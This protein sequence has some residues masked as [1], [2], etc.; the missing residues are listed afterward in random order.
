M[1]SKQPTASQTPSAEPVAP[2][3]KRGLLG[4]FFKSALGCTAFAFGVFVVLV[5]LLPTL[6][7]GWATGFAR[8]GFNNTFK[9]SVEIAKIDLAWFSEQRIDGVV[10]RDPDQ[11]EVARAAV[12]MPSLL[13]LARSGQ[14]RIGRVVLDVDADL[15]QDDGGLTNLQ[16]ALEPRHPAD[17]NAPEP[18][19]DAISDFDPIEWL[20][21]LEL[22]LE[23]RSKRLTWSD[24]ETRRIGQPFEVRELLTTVKARPKS[25][26]V[27]HTTGKIVAEKPGA[28][29]IDATIA[30]PITPAKA[31][32]LGKVDAQVR[33]EGFSTAMIDGLAGMQGNLTEVLGQRFT[34]KASVSAAALDAGKLEL[35]LDGERAGIALAAVLEGGVLRTGDK[36]G[37]VASF[38][39]PRGFLKT[40]IDPHLPS[41]SKLVLD[42]GTEPWS[43][44]AA[45]FSVPL[46]PPD[47][48]D[49]KSLRATLEQ[50]A[51]DLQIV[52]PSRFAF[53][54]EMTRAGGVQFALRNIK[55]SVRLAPGT[56]VSAHVE[57]ALESGTPGSFSFDVS[58]R[59]AWEKLAAD[60]LPIVDLELRVKELSTAAIGGLAGES[61][62]LTAA[63][64]RTLNISLDGKKVS[65]DAGTLTANIVGNEG[66]TQRLL[67]DVSARVEGGHMLI[68][69]ADKFSVR[70][71]PSQEWLSREIAAVAPEG[72]E[73]VVEAGANAVTIE[74]S[75]V[76]VPM[77][78]PAGGDYFKSL[79]S[80]AA[81]TLGVRVAGFSYADATLRAANTRVA[82]RSLAID[83]SLQAGGAFTTAVKG[84]FEQGTSRGKLVVDASGSDLFAF[85][86]PNTPDQWPPLDAKVLVSN[87]PAALADAFLQHQNIVERA[88]GKQISLAFDAKGVSTTKGSLRVEVEAPNAKVSFSGKVEGG[89]FKA[90]GDDA[91]HVE[92]RV[93]AQVLTAELADMLPADTQLKF[94][95][96]VAAL[97]LDVRD[98]AVPVPKLGDATPFDLAATLD[99]VSAKVNAT[100]AGVGIEN[101]QTQELK[102]DVVARNI[103]LE[104]VVAPRAPLAVKLKS[105]LAPGRDAKLVLEATLADPFAVLKDKPL[106]PLDAKIEL[107]GLDTSVLDAVAGQ[108]GVLAGLLGPELRVV[109]QANG[110]SATSGAL[111]IDANSP[112]MVFRT[113]ARFD[114]EGL[115]CEGEDGIDV[116][117]TPTAAFVE[118]YTRQVLP[119]GTR[120][121]LANDAGPL[122]VKVRNVL[123][124]LPKPAADPAAGGAPMS[125]DPA[126]AGAPMSSR[127]M[128]D[129]ISKLA[130][131]VEANVP[132][133]IYADAAT[134]AASRPVTLQNLR[135]ASTFKPNDLPFARVFGAIVDEPAGEI[136]AEVRALDPLTKLGEENGLATFRA[137]IDVRA[138]RVPTAILDM[139]AGQGGLLVEALG[140]RLDLTVAAPEISQTS[141]AFTLQMRSDLHGIVGAGHIE[142]G[143]IVVDHV[144]GLV[145]TVGLGPVMS[146][147]VVG[148]LVPTMVAVQKPA[149]ATPAIFAVDALRFP[150][151]G[152]LRKLDGSV[153][154][155]LGEVSYSLF[156]KLASFL[157][158]S[159]SMAPAKIPVITVPI[160]KGV[161]GYS[162]LPVKIGAKEYIFSGTY[163]MVTDAAQ[164]T[165]NVPVSVLGKQVSSELDKLREYIDPALTLPLTIKGSLLNPSIGVDEKGL[166]K[167]IEDAGKKA[168]EKAGSGL[169]DDLF[170][171]KKKD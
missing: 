29:S 129:Q 151:D 50:V 170:K 77:P 165:A 156:P 162:R 120:I 92:A 14:T 58:A 13:A 113:A 127:D 126:A 47:A 167:V 61:E 90:A 41:G 159:S 97:T 114:A 161:A 121:Q 166:R 100:I 102:L 83:A 111:V 86:P 26:I 59:D 84:D 85:A 112:T 154:V 33:V 93:P 118:R 107:S 95:N 17:P 140:S 40:Y 123:V 63:I 72:T 43:A 45:Q 35:T 28:L 78:D 68:D 116:R 54:N 65:L 16:R 99:A 104:A 155:D 79:R 152:D 69:G 48:R 53:E 101:A 1:A 125:S 169:I 39:A 119:A 87:L 106:S 136:A 164:L 108:D 137:K 128:L 131:Q 24:P 66:A 49:L 115:R 30:G 157:N 163:D 142:S 2:K 149:G 25:P 42:P 98:L 109:V 19:K 18:S 34:F 52:V 57:A 7:S 146:Q 76:K 132:T 89:V 143:M 82:V 134:D 147:R 94:P 103:V 60:A 70:L 36:P 117:L 56:P 8:D 135:I 141:G 130:F 74:A 124:P 5:L 23:V 148:K 133:L 12:V 32:P 10:I 21:Q 138:S 91:L 171:K 67:V 22:D 4:F 44:T 71:S 73:L 144:D 11:R 38:P 62:R 150:L 6:S 27:V 37:L 88:L 3:K 20:S 158:E 80:A 168:L 15:V 75:N 55:T 51:L 139:L 145:A 9:G 105:D 153:R 64:G 81:G 110:A 96:Q 31:W 46:P 160:T 122:T